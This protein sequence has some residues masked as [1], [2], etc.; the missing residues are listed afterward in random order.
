MSVWDEHLPFSGY[1]PVLELLWSSK[2]LHCFELDQ[3]IFR[4]V[5][6]TELEWGCKG[7]W[8]VR[9]YTYEIT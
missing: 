5:G 4:R 8:W 2:V 3:A 1:L 6:T 7:D 9:Y